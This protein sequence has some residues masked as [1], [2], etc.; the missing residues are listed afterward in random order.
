MKNNQ[1]TITIL[2]GLDEAC[3]K[4]QGWYTSECNIENGVTKSYATMYVI[5]KNSNHCFML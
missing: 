2:S 1:I 5:Q 3:F 4:Y